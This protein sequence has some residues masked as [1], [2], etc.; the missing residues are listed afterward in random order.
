MKLSVNIEKRYALTIIGLL[1]VL[2][3]IFTVYA[4]NSNP[5]KPAVFG[6]S[7]EEVQGTIVGGGTVF[8]DALGVGAGT[9]LPCVDST[10]DGPLNKAS[11]NAPKYV[12]GEAFCEP[13]TNNKLL[14]CR[15]ST[16]TIIAVSA[17]YLN[18]QSTPKTASFYLCIKN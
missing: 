17:G 12:W 4:Y 8:G 7:A 18:Y 1:I 3:G 5:P 13:G 6:H 16:R 14:K 11:T 10:T 2:A 15:N 9:A